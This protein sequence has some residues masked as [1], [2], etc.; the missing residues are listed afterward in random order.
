[1]SSSPPLSCI[2]V[3]YD[4]CGHDSYVTYFW[5]VHMM[6]ISRTQCNA[7]IRCC[8]SSNASTTRY[9]RGREKGVDSYDDH[10]MIQRIEIVSDHNIVIA[11]NYPPI[12]A[13]KLE[14]ARSHLPSRRSDRERE[15]RTD[16]MRP[17]FASKLRP[18]EE[19][20]EI[21]P[22]YPPWLLS[23]AKMTR[24]GQTNEW[25]VQRRNWRSSSIIITPR[26]PTR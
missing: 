3:R 8:F 22:L 16:R 4:N 17:W 25:T 11:P 14:G 12:N 20:G 23:N 19:N 18:N 24:Y 10:H 2:T 6:I 5:W 26:R 7:V 13:L 15:R 21:S 1:M 9:T